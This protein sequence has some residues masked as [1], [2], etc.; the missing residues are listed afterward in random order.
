VRQTGRQIR[1]GEKY[2]RVMETNCKK[3]TDGRKG[4]IEITAKDKQ[5][6]AIKPGATTTMTLTWSEAVMGSQLPER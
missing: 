5:T 3:K 2:E 1:N 6:R 4:H